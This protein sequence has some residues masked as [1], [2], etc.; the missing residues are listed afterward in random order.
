MKKI[1]RPCPFW[2]MLLVSNRGDVKNDISG[3]VY[4]QL[5]KHGYKTIRVR[6]ALTGKRIQLSVHRL[7]LVSFA[8]WPPKGKVACHV[9]GKRHDNKIE[10][11]MW[12]TQ[13]EN[14]AQRDAHGTTMKGDNHYCAKITSKQARRAKLLLSKS[15]TAREV[16]KIVGASVSTINDIKRGRSWKHA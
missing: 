16:A 12:A 11:L 4:A 10:N 8:G 15:Y 14:I 7:V 5:E 9:N 6:E 1:W 3:H 2:P 13:D